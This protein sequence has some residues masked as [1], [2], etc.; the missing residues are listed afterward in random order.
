MNELRVSVAERCETYA[1]GI[2]PTQSVLETNS[3]ALEHG[4]IK[5]PDRDVIAK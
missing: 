2:E 5:K 3:P 1:V 4:R